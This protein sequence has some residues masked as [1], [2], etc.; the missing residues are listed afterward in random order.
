MNWLRVFILNFRYKPLR[1]GR[2][3]RPGRNDVADISQRLVRPI[4]STAD[5]DERQ[6]GVE[7]APFPLLPRP[8]LLPRRSLDGPPPAP[9]YGQ[10]APTLAALLWILEWRLRSSLR[11]NRRPHTSHAKGFSPVW[12]RKCVVRWSERLN[13]RVHTR[14]WNGFCPVWI[15][16]CR[17][18]SSL[19]ENLRSHRSTGH[20]CVRSEAGRP[21]TDNGWS[22]PLGPATGGD[23]SAA[24]ATTL[25]C[26]SP[27]QGVCATVSLGS[28]LDRS[29]T[30]D[31]WWCSTTTGKLIVV[32]CGDIGN[33]WSTL[34]VGGSM[35]IPVVRML[36]TIRSDTDPTISGVEA[37]DV[38]ANRLV[39]VGDGQTGPADDWLASWNRMKPPVSTDW[40]G[41]EVGCFADDTTSPSSNT[42]AVSSGS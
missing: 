11:A 29:A 12:V 14:H 17:V 33:G 42:K 23:A 4:V 27:M 15:L 10:L 24:V 40:G 3:D 20:T 5:S 26:D 25:Q 38:L 21:P 35:N 8:R 37:G 13:D 6:M 41:I 1:D 16:T 22:S 2:T 32:V 36:A 30:G 28:A 31:K 19:R 18:S 39:V 9:A 34:V 7:A